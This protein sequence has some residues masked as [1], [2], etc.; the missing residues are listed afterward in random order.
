MIINK[1][2]GSNVALA[3]VFALTFKYSL[4]SFDLVTMDQNVTKTQLKFMLNY[5]ALDINAYIVLFKSFGLLLLLTG[6]VLFIALIGVNLVL[7]QYTR[8]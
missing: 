7:N 6:V 3:L 2:I 1:N 4:R 5:T 8:K